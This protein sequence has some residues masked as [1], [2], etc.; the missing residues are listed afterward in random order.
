MCRVIQEAP[1]CAPI[2]QLPGCSAR[3]CRYHHNADLGK[4][5]ASTR[6]GGSNGGITAEIPMH[7]HSEGEPGEGR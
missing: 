4:G 2:S 6:E 3:T 5:A 7:H 1:P